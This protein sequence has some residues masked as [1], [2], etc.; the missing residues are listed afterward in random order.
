MHVDL[1]TEVKITLRVNKGRHKVYLTATDRDT[2]VPLV[3][4]ESNVCA[5]KNAQGVMD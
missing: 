2:L 5:L 3:L 1:H 4:L